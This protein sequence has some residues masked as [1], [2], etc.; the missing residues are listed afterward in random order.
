MKIIDLYKTYKMYIRY[1]E[2]F[3]SLVDEM[4]MLKRV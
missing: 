3:F 2:D 1:I 4:P